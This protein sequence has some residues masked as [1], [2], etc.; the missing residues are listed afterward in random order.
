VIGQKAEVAPVGTVKADV[1]DAKPRQRAVGNGAGQPAIALDRDEIDDTAQ[2]TPRD[3][4]GATGALGDLAGAFGVGLD[5]Q[6]PRATGDDMVKLV[7][8][9]EL[10]TRGNAETVAQRCGQKAQ[11]RRGAHQRE[12]LQLNPHRARRRPLADH[13][14]EREILHRGVEHLFHHRTKA[15]NFI[16]KQ[17]VIGFKI[18]QDRRQ[19]PG[20]GQHRTR[21]HPKPHPQL[22]RHDLRQGGLAQTGGAVEQRVVHRLAADLGAFDEDLQIGAGLGLANK[23]LQH[24]RAQ[25]AVKVFGQFFGAKGGIRL[26]QRAFGARSFSAARIRPWVSASGNSPAAVEIACAASPCP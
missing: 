20:L 23:I 24:L 11:P 19:I 1:I 2:K 4:R 10:Q 13:E 17:H 16:D 12:G 22:A 5:A 3:P 18:G 8:G 25:G 15:M 7:L 9:V 21:G 6:E 26:H 14:I